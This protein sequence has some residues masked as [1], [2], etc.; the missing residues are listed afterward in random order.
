VN[1]L[2]ESIQF[3]VKVLGLVEVERHSDSA[4][5]MVNQHKVYLF[6]GTD[7]AQEYRHAEQAN[8]KLVFNVRSLDSALSWLKSHHVKIVHDDVNKNR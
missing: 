5:L 8:S 6:E 4:V 2:E 1:D 3:Y 7:V